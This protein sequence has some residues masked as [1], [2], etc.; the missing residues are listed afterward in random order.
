MRRRHHFRV[1]RCLLPLLTALGGC[2]IFGPHDCSLEFVYGIEVVVTDRDSGQPVIDGLSG[3]TVENGVVSTMMA[4]GNRLYGAGENAGL[5][6]VL[7]NA[8]GYR[9]WS[10]DRVRVEDEGCHVSTAYLEAALVPDGEG[11]E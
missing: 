7:V 9:Q 11:F 3:T 10:A 2:G 4:S 6:A 1:S 5:H 8:P